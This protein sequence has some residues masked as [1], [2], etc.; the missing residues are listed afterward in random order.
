MM[1]LAE[2]RSRN[3]AILRDFHE[4]MTIKTR[5]ALARIDRIRAEG[6]T[7]IRRDTTRPIEETPSARDIAAMFAPEKTA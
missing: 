3:A 5:A 7:A 6:L 4:D 1:T 2:M